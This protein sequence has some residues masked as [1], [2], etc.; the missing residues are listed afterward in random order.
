MKLIFIPIA[1]SK[2]LHFNCKAIKFEKK[3]IL[4]VSQFISRIFYSKVNYFIF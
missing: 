1:K 3:M 2:N 4:N